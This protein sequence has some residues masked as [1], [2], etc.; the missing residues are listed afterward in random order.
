[1]YVCKY[2]NYYT[3]CNCYVHHLVDLRLTVDGPS[4]AI[5]GSNISI[6]C[7]VLEGYPLPSVFIITPRGQVNQPPVTF[8]VTLEDAGNYTCV[9]NNSVDTVTSNLSLTVYGTYH[10]NIILSNCK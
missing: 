10:A 5:V 7:N 6:R 2:N 1:M 4:E 9:A 3:L 8:N